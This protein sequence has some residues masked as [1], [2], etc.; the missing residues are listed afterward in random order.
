M[1]ET[2]RQINILIATGLYPPDIGGPATH[3]V[4]L[5]E[6]L[7]KDQFALT[8]VPFGEV[9]K[10]PKVIR[11]VVYAWR[12]WRHAKT[13]DLIYALDGVS[14]G[15]PALLV[16]KLRH[17][18]LVV[19]LGG[20]YAW[21]QGVVRYGVTELPHQFKAVYK[22]YGLRIRLL[23]ALQHYVVRAACHIVLPS[24]Y[25]KNVFVAW[26]HNPNKISVIYNPHEVAATPH[27]RQVSSAPLLLAAGRLNAIKRFPGIVSMVPALLKQFPTLRLE[28]AG[29]GPDRALIE[30]AI[31][32]HGVE[33]SVTLLGALN[34]S[35]LHQKMRLADVFIQNSLHE[36]FPHI[37]LEAMGEGTPV[38]ATAVGG[39]VEIIESENNGLLV[40]ANN[41]SA[42]SA[43]IVRLLQDQ[44]LYQQLV[45]AGQESIERFSPQIVLTQLASVFRS[46][47]T[48]SKQ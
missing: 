33:N 30:A 26:G 44:A 15:L 7:P 13:A 10:Y 21:E 43:A 23:S 31:V 20:D 5:E 18:P 8:V 4:F 45:R 42:L 12:L 22:Q 35:E 24:V 11:H 9:R 32:E 29:D 46:T 2:D 3:T 38:I 1:A 14:V 36:S 37:L 19:R 48:E 47:T 39:T 28:I 25:L 34:K 27:D 40:D 6:N 17:R 41:P 16:S